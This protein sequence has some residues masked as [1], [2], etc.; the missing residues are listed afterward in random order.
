MLLLVGAALVS[1]A[2][3]QAQVAPLPKPQT[4]VVTIKVM[5]L[6]LL[7]PTTP[8]FRFGAEYRISPLWGLEASYGHQMRNLGWGYGG[9]KPLHDRFQKAHL[10]GR[11]YMPASPFYAAVA[12]FRVGQQFDAGA[13]TFFRDGERWQYTSARVQRTVLGGVVKLGVV[14]PLDAHWRLD[15]AVGGGLRAG[16]IRY[17]TREESR[18][19]PTAFGFYDEWECGFRPDFG[20]TTTPGTFRRAT[21]AVEVRLGYEL[22]R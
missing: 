19:D 3:A 20:P 8:T 11:Y 13:G 7:D 16:N 6:A 5:P 2:G 15:M 17:Q 1:G 4:G 12:G 18:L 9:S 10:E 21:L 22:G 14:I